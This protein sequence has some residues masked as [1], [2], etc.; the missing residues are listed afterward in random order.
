MDDLES[1]PTDNRTPRITGHPRAEHADPGETPDV[2]P[3][4]FEPPDF[5]PPDPLE[6]PPLPDFD[7][8]DPLDP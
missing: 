5:E 7:P 1:P 2:G 3:P 4:D 8:P 6:P